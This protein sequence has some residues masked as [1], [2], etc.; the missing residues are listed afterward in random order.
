MLRIE[1][2]FKEFLP[3]LGII[4]PVII[5]T[6]IGYLADLFTLKFLPL[7]VNSIIASI[8][9]DFIIGL[10]LSFS[11][12]TSLAGFL[13]TIELRQEFSI[14]KDYL[15]QAVMFGIVSGLFF[16]IFRFIPFSIFLD[17]LSVSFLFVLYSFT[18]K[19]KS[20]IGYSLDWIS[21]AIGQDFLS[22]LILYLLALLSFFPVSDIICIPLGA[23]L[24]Y[25]LRR[26]LS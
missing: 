15:S 26:D 12:C 11:I 24:A 4:L 7:F 25:N 5:I 20:S 14:L 9:A 22:F 6:I 16:F 17:A 3:K 1:E 2:T 13:F 8:V 18:F 19:G 10:M 21:R 23:I